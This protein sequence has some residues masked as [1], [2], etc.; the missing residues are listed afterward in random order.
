MKLRISI[1]TLVAAA[2]LAVSLHTA[3]AAPVGFTLSY[4]DHGGVTVKAGDKVVFRDADA[5]MMINTN[6]WHGVYG[7]STE[8]WATNMAHPNRI[9]T[10]KGDKKVVTFSDPGTSP[11]QITKQVTEISP[12]EIKIVVKVN[13][14][15]SSQANL[16]DYSGALPGATYNG[17]T[18]STDGGGYP[19][20][21]VS[22][23]TPEWAKKQNGGHGD[24]MRYNITT[25]TFNL[26]DLAGAPAK[27]IY[28][29]T[30]TPVSSGTPPNV[31]GWR[32]AAQPTKDGVGQFQIRSTFDFNPS[33]PFERVVELR[34]AWKD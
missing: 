27:L 29:L 11:I 4:D 30:E 31:R 13:T 33:A 34:L 26:K 24:D 16:M 8:P 1:K 7:W 22:P 28:T 6:P 18:Y 14:P 15:A 17:A 23:L 2:L 32:I 12:R 9:D 20:D 19:L 5:L 25:A 21:D 3:S 10:T